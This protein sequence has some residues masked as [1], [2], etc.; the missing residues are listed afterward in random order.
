[1]KRTILAVLVLVGFAFA[2][3]SLVISAISRAERIDTVKATLEAPT[4]RWINPDTTY[5]KRNAL[6]GS[7]FWWYNPGTQKMC[8]TIIIWR[9]TELGIDLYKY[10]PIW[11]LHF[12]RK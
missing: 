6:I 9:A 7:R 8:D 10:S 5:I 4:F 3:D 12:E 2:A 11:K 1:M